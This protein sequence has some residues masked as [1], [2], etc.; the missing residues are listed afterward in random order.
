MMNK[1]SQLL[2]SATL[3]AVNSTTV[4]GSGSQDQNERYNTRRLLQES[5]CTLYRNNVQ[6]GSTEDHPNG[7]Q[8]ETWACELSEED[9]TRLNVQFV[10]IA[11]SSAVT[12][13]ANSKSGE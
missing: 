4:R 12:K 1:F 7:Y 2:L 9:S 5:T 8:E 11:E 10:D 3:V 6:Y 13:I